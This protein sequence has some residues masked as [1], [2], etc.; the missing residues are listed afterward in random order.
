[1]KKLVLVL[2]LVG[3]SINTSFATVSDSIVKSQGVSLTK[4]EKDSIILGIEDVI[5]E[6]YPGSKVYR[7]FESRI[8]DYI[9]Q[10][11]TGEKSKFT[12]DFPDTYVVITFDQKPTVDMIED[13]I[14]MKVDRLKESGYPITPD[15]YFSKF[16]ERDGKIF[17]VVALDET[18]IYSRNKKA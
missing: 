9:D 12:S 17:L 14:Q 8:D 2:A 5:L 13:I 10:K 4:S 3:I 6:N 11:L 15:R 1:M 7:L 18:Y 16:V